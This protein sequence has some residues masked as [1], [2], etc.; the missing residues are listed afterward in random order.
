MEHRDHVSRRAFL[1][2]ATAGAAG[3]AFAAPPTIAAPHGRTCPVVAM[4]GTGDFGP[5]TPGT[6]TSGIQEAIDAVHGAGGGTVALR[7]GVYMVDHSSAPPEEARQFA[8]GQQSLGVYDDIAL[9]GEGMDQTVIRTAAQCNTNAL[10]GW[11]TFRV[12]IED[13]TFD[14]A[15]LNKGYGIAIFGMGTSFHDVVVRR[16]RC[17]GFGGSAIGIAG[18]ER[19]VLEQ[20]ATSGAKI[21]FELGA[22]SKDYWVLHCTAA[23]CSN[24]T[25]ILDPADQFNEAG[26][27]H[28]HIIGGRYD[29]GGTASGVALWDCYEP[30]VIGVTALGGVTT[31]LQIAPSGRPTITTPVGG[32]LLLGCVAEGSHGSD[33]GRYG[34]GAFQDGVRVIGCSITG[35]EDA[36]VFA[37]PGAA[38]QVI[39]SQCTFHRGS[40]GAQQYAIVCGDGCAL[41]ASNNQHDGPPE[42]FLG[43]ASALAVPGSLVTGNTGFSPQG[44]L[45]PPAVPASGEWLANDRPWPVDIHVYAGIVS[46]ISKRDAA[47][48]EGIVAN[49]TP[50]QVRLWPGEAIRL[51]YTGAPTWTWFGE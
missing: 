41:R 13:L 14:G 24:G 30:V 5:E 26:N 43:N 15:G 8:C 6:T 27:L 42:R 51:T 21:G 35:N 38:G 29:G 12:R 47:G 25:L 31:N 32:G 20:C 18:G 44:L 1:G 33:A 48:R 11:Q 49:R 40:D 45:P 16:V 37:R 9:V 3:A 4:D 10:L 7:R 28:P 34:V 19:V 2:I 22:P 36:G 17:L 46:E 50:A 23:E 39:V